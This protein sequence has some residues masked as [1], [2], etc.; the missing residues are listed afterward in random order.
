MKIKLQSIKLLQ[1]CEALY[2][3]ELRGFQARRQVKAVVYA[4]RRLFGKRNLQITIGEH[5]AW[6]PDKARK[7]AERLLRELGIGND[8]RTT[9]VVGLTLAEAASQFMEHIREKRAEEPPESIRAIFTSI[10]Y[11]SWAKCRLT[12]L[13]LLRSRDYTARS[14]SGR[15]SQTASWRHSRASMDGPKGST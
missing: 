10:C 6:A 13:R 3:T 1:P 4:V 15:Y 11:R 12:K 8:P 14:G 9:R 5:G 7:E 2:D